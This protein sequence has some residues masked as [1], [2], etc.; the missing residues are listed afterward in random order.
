MVGHGKKFPLELAQS[1][2]P[3]EGME[4]KKLLMADHGCSHFHGVG[5]EGGFMGPV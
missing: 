1:G 5:L 3:R 2:K 4:V